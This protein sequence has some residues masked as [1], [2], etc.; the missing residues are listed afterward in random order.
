MKLEQFQVNTNFLNSLPREWSKFVI[1]VK[2]VR[3]LHTTNFDQLHAYLE[4]YELHANEV[5]RQNYL[6]AARRTGHNVKTV[7]KAKEEKVGS[8][9]MVQRPGYCKGPVT[10]S[11]ITHNAAYQA[12]DL[13]AYDSDLKH[14]DIIL[15]S[16]DALSMKPSD[17]LKSRVD[18]TI[19]VKN[20]VS[21]VNT[22]FKKLKYHLGLGQF[23]NVVKKRITPDALT[24]GEWGFEHTKAVFLKEI[25]SFLKTLKDIFNDFDKDLLNEITEVQTVF[26]QMEVV[27]QQYHVDKQC[28]EIQKKQIL[29]E[30]DRLLDQIISQD[31]VTI[32][33]NSSMDINTSMNV[34]SSVAMNDSMNYVEIKFKGKDIVN[35]AAHVSNDTT[36]ALGMYKLDRVTLVPK[37]KNNRE[38]HIYYHK[39]TMEQAAILREIVEQAKSLNPLDSTS[40][41]ACKYVKLIQELLGY[42]R[43]TCLDI[44]KPSE[45]LVAIMPINKKKTVRLTATNRVP[46]RVPIPL[47]VVASK[48]VVSRVYT[49]RP[50]VPKSVPNSKPKVAKSMTANRM[51]PGTSRGSDTSVAPS[52]FSLIDCR[53]SKLFYVLSNSVMT[54]LEGM[55]G[56]D[57]EVAF[58]KNTCFVRNLEGVD[59]LLGSQG[60]NLYSM[61]I[62]DMME[63]S[64]ISRHGLVRGLPRLKFEKDHLCSACAMGKS[65]KQSH[66]PKSEDTN[67]EKLY[68]LHMDLCGPMR[69]ASVNR[70]NYILVIVDDYS[71]FTWVKFLA[72]KDEALDFIIKFLKMIQ[73][74]LNA[75]IRR[76]LYNNGT[77]FVKSNSTRLL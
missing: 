17:S 70:K 36:I 26:N 64:L 32:V 57:L 66:K 27:V 47:E 58:R 9:T 25:I 37:D 51:E 3:D 63:S 20:K 10:P 12:D 62:R 67:Q 42:V 49:K 48:H 45:K 65:K 18:P 21:Q 76:H 2:L 60:T 31:I 11:V 6:S 35:N 52:S 28:F 53:L 61:S 8:A 13:D 44:H 69:V 5:R 14:C 43:D 24:E 68:L 59:L 39:H 74:R 19:C 71:Q 77:E 7:T 34:N 38:T 41:S 30:N 72:S 50:K 46:L 23:D 16:A 1:D 33:V 40:Y 56:R 29:I 15:P 4:Q 54:K 55:M 22:S 73:V 75:T